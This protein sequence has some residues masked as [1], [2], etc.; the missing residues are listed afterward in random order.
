MIKSSQINEELVKIDRPKIP[1]KLIRIKLLKNELKYM[2]EHPNF[3][4]LNASELL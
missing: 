1:L 4:S 3:D 2:Q